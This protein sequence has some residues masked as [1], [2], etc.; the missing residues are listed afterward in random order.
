VQYAAHAFLFLTA[1]PKHGAEEIAV[2][3]AMRSHT[4][5]FSGSVRS[6]WT[7]YFGAGLMIILAGIVEVVSLGLLAGLAKSDPK[8][9]TP[10]IALFLFANL[11]HA[12]LAATCFFLT[13]VLADLVVSG[14]LAGALVAA[15]SQTRQRAPWIPPTSLPQD[16]C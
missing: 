1:R 8:R 11:A 3:E 16:S 2:L 14:L 9:A 4:F 7:M 6:Y 15:R 12:A 10:F 5:D 13:P